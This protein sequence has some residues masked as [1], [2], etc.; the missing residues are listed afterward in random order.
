MSNNRHHATR[1][2][3]HNNFALKLISELIEA[4]GHLL[5][6]IPVD[7][8]LYGFFNTAGVHRNEVD[9]VPNFYIPERDIHFHVT[10][11]FLSAEEHEVLETL[12]EPFKVQ[13]SDTVK[14][15]KNCLDILKGVG[16]DRFLAISALAELMEQLYN[17]TSHD[18]L[19]VVDDYNWMFKG[20][21][22]KSFRYA[23]VPGLRGGV[24]GYHMALMRIF[25]RFDGHLMRRGFKLVGNSNRTIERH[26]FAPE[27]INFSVHHAMKLKGMRSFRE[28]YGF[29]MFLQSNNLW[30][31]SHRGLKYAM[32]LFM[33]TQGNF[34][35]TTELARNPMI[36]EFQNNPGFQKRKRK[37][38]LRNLK[39]LYNKISY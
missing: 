21:A 23:S 24:P 35:A 32:K 39:K 29:V 38:K 33:E 9:P 27:K 19:L 16:E 17:Q 28:F 37:P 5:E 2:Y 1:L 34:I 13:I 4:Q 3:L 22:E 10:D 7:L 15:P 25:M 30:Q 12:N 26:Y 11:E 8:S 14:E 20:S 36:R 6:E 31:D 18:V